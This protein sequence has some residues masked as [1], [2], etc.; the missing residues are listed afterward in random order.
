MHERSIDIR[1]ALYNTLE[2]VV[3]YLQGDSSIHTENILQRLAQVMA[4]SKRR[5]LINDNINFDIELISSVVCLD[6]LDQF[7]G[8]GKPHR[9]V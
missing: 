6:A 2:I 5:V 4:I 1:N 9:H 3:L 8:F 7:D